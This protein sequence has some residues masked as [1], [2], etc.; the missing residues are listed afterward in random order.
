MSTPQ[1]PTGRRGLTIAVT[2]GKGGVGKTALTV[3]LSIALARLDFRVGILDA[4]FGL[5]NV[6]WMLGLTPISHIGAVMT[7]E[8][9]LGGIGATTV[10]G[11]RIFP[12]G[13]GIR[14]LT[15]LP[16]GPWAR[17]Q[18]RHRRPEHDAA[19]LP[20]GRHRPRHRRHRPEG[21]ARH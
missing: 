5:G 3:N 7:G 17:L 8:K 11:V 6:G 16:G 4:D 15:S 12:A 1:S 2:S 20:A 13:N 10:S 21:G 18:S 9:A 19:R 14:S